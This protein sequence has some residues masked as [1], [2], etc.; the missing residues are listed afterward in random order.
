[1]NA[2]A[3]A[4]VWLGA[5]GITVCF[6]C[7]VLFQAAFPAP[8]ERLGSFKECS[9]EAGPKADQIV[10]IGSSLTRNAFPVTP[11]VGGLLADGRSHKLWW[12]PWI[13]ADETLILI[14]CASAL[15][16]ETV[17]VET[18]AFVFSK[19]VRVSASGSDGRFIQASGKNYIR[20]FTHQ[21]R[22]LLKPRT[23][24]RWSANIK[25][26]DNKWD[27]VRPKR[28]LLP[29]NNY[30]ER[31]FS[32][33]PANLA[34]DVWLFEPPRTKLRVDDI[35]TWSGKSLQALIEKVNISHGERQLKFWQSW[36]DQFF[37]DY[38]SHMN[39][40]GRLRFLQELQAAWKEAQDAE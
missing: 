23:A 29:T 31:G 34:A 6:V 22:F 18:N 32:Q 3:Y 39:A 36:P 24:D 16:A 17:L 9:H 4:F 13:S 27:G 5:I 19:N 20:E 35:E 25:R 7:F 12:L 21:V 30:E 26:N 14:N 40:E 10:V 38:A 11:P 28:F 37:N 33:S 8:L 1:M 2:R 15:G